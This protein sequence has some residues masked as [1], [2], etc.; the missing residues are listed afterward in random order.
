[1]EAA[2]KFVAYLLLP[3]FLAIFTFTQLFSSR[4]F[5]YST[6]TCHSTERDNNAGP[7]S[8]SFN[9]TPFMHT[10]TCMHLQ[11]VSLFCCVSKMFLKNFLFLFLCFLQIFSF[12][13]RQICVRLHSLS[14]CQCESRAPL[15]IHHLNGK[16]NMCMHACVH[17]EL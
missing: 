9:D 13:F 7:T 6:I 8:V 1:M 17:L 16:V 10:Q 15:L 3:R 11:E 2:R 12:G 14:P 5:P 4:L